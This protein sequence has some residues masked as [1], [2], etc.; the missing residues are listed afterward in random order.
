MLAII[1][2][3]G[4]LWVSGTSGSHRFGKY[5][6]VVKYRILQMTLIAFLWLRTKMFICT[7]CCDANTSLSIKSLSSF[8]IINFLCLFPPK[9][10]N[11]FNLVYLTDISYDWL[12]LCFDV[13]F[14]VDIACQY[15]TKCFSRIRLIVNIFY[16]RLIWSS[17]SP[18]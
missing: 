12:K 1:R 14:A 11:G 5:C 3:W 15:H 17:S 4:T 18:W 13:Y 16:W 9:P 7:I 2:Q 8:L 6:T 10:Y